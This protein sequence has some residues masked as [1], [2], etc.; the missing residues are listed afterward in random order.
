MM[1]MLLTPTM[2]TMI[3]LVAE[4]AKDVWC[5]RDQRGG[6]GA[7]AKP[8]GPKKTATQSHGFTQC[9]CV[10]PCVRRKKVCEF[11]SVSHTHTRFTF[12]AGTNLKYTCNRVIMIIHIK[13]HLSWYSACD[14]ESRLSVA[15][16]AAR[17]L[18]KILTFQ[19]FLLTPRNIQPCLPLFTC[20][21]VRQDQLVCVQKGYSTFRLVSHS[22]VRLRRGHETKKVQQ[23]APRKR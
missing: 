9:L 10:Y 1:M 20:A 15:P 12:T 17:L 14:S 3:T 4:C 7:E 13:C 23:S 16:S 22:S 8:E 6:R 21:V 2:A 11:N 5:K 18:V 19:I